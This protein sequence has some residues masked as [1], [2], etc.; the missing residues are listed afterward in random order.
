MHAF[1]VMMRQVKREQKLINLK[2]KNSDLQDMLPQYQDAL[3]KLRES[4]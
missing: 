4:I 1:N 2:I 3:D